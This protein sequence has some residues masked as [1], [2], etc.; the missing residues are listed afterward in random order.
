MLSNLAN[1][2][3]VIC[4]IGSNMTKLQVLNF[5]VI[6]QWINRVFIIVVL[7]AIVLSLS[8]NWSEVQ[9]YDWQVQPF[10][11]SLAVLIYLA[12]FLLRGVTWVRI[13]NVLNIPLPR[14]TGLRIYLYTYISRYIPGGLWLLVTINATAHSLGV[15][16]RVFTFALFFNMSLLAFVDIIYFLPF[17]HELIG[18]MSILLYGAII[19]MFPIILRFG[20]SKLSRFNFVPESADIGHFTQTQN[21]FQL[22]IMT[23]IHQVLQLASYFVFVYAVMSLD[24]SQ[25]MYIT[26][27]YGISW[28]IGFMIVIVPQGLGVREVT[29]VFL[30]SPLINPEIAILLSVALRLLTIT[31]ELTAFF[32]I[33]GYDKLSASST[34]NSST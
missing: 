13:V 22:L 18:V 20:L 1:S 24:I 26:I 17:I 21:I 15:S 7:V 28:L 25:I 2:L 29:F 30:T 32:L 11:V 3:I 34:K 8:N 12:F 16:K 6:R 4:L 9:S 23:I 31:G 14:H 27:A 10:F 19:Y 33:L 5:R